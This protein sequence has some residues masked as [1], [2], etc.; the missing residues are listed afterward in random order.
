MDYVYDIGEM[1]D[2][3]HARIRLDHAHYYKKT[4][5]SIDCRLQIA[6]DVQCIGG[7]S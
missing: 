2:E 6:D 1:F 7:D 4:E 3:Y 5:N